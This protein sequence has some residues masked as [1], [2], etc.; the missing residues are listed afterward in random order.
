M[1][2]GNKTNTLFKGLSIQTLIT[3]IMGVLEITYFAVMSRL[4]T[5]TD[6]GYFAAIGGVMAICMSLLDGILKKL[7]EH[8]SAVLLM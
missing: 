1:T 8:T 4:L 5:K 7:V 6:F 2:N 3:I